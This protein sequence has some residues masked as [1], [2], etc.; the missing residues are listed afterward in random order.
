MNINEC[1]DNNGYYYPDNDYYTH[2]YDPN[3]YIDY[4][5]YDA[6]YNNYEIYE[7]YDPTIN[8]CPSN[9]NKVNEI[10]SIG[11]EAQPSTSHSDQDFPV[12]PPLK[13]LK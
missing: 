2:D 7:Y 12:S 8:D 4:T 3:Y 9:G 1:Y 13:L 10:S 11:A 5:N 6:D